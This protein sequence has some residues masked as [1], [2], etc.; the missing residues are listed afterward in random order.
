MLPSVAATIEADP[1]VFLIGRPPMTEYLG[2]V[3]SQTV[4]G[5]NADKRVLAEAWRAAND[6]VVRL[7][8]D[9]AG[10]ADNVEI[11]ALPP[12][13]ESLRD[14]ALADPIVQ[15]TYALTPIDIG[16]VD[17]DRLVVFQKKIN[18]AHAGRL[19]SLVEAAATSEEIFR[20]CLPY[21]ARFDPPTAYGASGPASW[22]FKSPSNDFR[23][24]DARVLDSAAVPGLAISGVPT[25]VVAVSVGYGP[26]YLS[27][28]HVEGRLV[29]WN[30]SHRAYALR[31]AGH[32]HVPCLI[33]HVSRRDE[34]E[35]HGGPEHEVNAEPD[36]YLTAPRPPLLKDYFDDE[37]RL[38]ADVQRNVRQVQVGVNIGAADLPT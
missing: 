10:V 16:M 18:L 29:L 5:Q 15:R 8:T 4:D 30:G 1:H 26:N 33:Q 19:R 36:R 34:L 32:T 37:L 2:F 11:E 14:R 28:L 20:L 3:I 31:E 17:L 25:H 7:E 35:A 24:L 12:E 22:V 27:A 9:E 13:L 6:H 38:V 23:V 21:E